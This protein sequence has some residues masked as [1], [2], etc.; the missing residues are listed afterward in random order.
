MPLPYTRRLG[1]GISGEPFVETPFYTALDVYTTILRDVIFVSN[2]DLANAILLIHRPG[3]PSTVLWALA[4]TKVNVTQHLDFRQELLPSE[5]LA[6]I[7]SGPAS[8]LVCI[9][10]GYLLSNP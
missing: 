5:Q 6:I 10:T 7:S 2:A 4:G 1:I 8:S 3:G 9:V